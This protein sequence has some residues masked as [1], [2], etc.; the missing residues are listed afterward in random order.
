MKKEETC[1]IKGHFICTNELVD[2]DGVMLIYLI[3]GLGSILKLPLCYHLMFSAAIS[4]LI[5]PHFAFY[6][7]TFHHFSPCIQYL[8]LI[9]FAIIASKEFYFLMLFFHLFFLF[10][11][12]AHYP[13]HTLSHCYLYFFLIARIMLSCFSATLLKSPHFPVH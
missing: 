9:F 2:H 11:V 8:C 7:L 5:A 4:L 13:Y 10:S 6:F 1:N 3:G 12:S